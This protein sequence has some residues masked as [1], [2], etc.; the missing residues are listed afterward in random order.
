MQPARLPAGKSAAKAIKRAPI[1]R[2]K[3]RPVPSKPRAKTAPAKP[4]R[5][6]AKT[7]VV[8]TRQA[9]SKAFIGDDFL[10]S[11]PQAVE[12]FHAYAQ[13]QPIVDYHCHLPPDRIASDQP[14]ANLT[15]IWLGGDHYKWRAMRANGIDERLI[16]GD[17]PDREK[18]AAWAE[19]V[20]KCLRNPLYHWT[21]L[22]L[23]RPFGITDKLLGPDTAQD[24]WDRANSK[25]ARAD[26]SPRGIMRQMNVKVVCTTD[27]PVDDLAHHQATAI[28]GFDVQVRPTWRPDKGLLVD[29]PALFNPWLDRLSA[30][31]GIAIHTWEDFQAAL[32]NRHQ[33]FHVAGCRLSD[34]GLDTVYAEDYSLAEIATIFAAARKGQAADPLATARFKSAMLFEG[35]VMDH[36]AGW[37]Q[38][39]HIGAIRNTNSRAALRGPDLGYDSIGEADYAAPLARLLDRL[40]KNDRLAR[41]ILYNLNPRTNEVLATMIGNFQDGRTPGKMQFGSGWWFLDQKDG[42]EKQIDCLSNMGLL[43]RFVGMLTD[44]RSFL[45]YT[46]HEYFRRILC[47]KL[48][49]EMADGLLPNDIGMI[50]NLVAD[51]CYRNAAAYFDFGL[52][53]Q[54]V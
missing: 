32:A 37:V 1:A 11:T 38:Q 33:F 40:D 36:A 2:A 44:S 52:P 6:P 7:T 41:T 20:P 8:R 49:R 42:M 31:S 30:A 14:F 28:S 45:S 5:P 51:V 22:E 23:R 18:F 39:F 13:Q 26:F 27:D 53:A 29:Q 48:G 17:A 19:T 47:N 3:P 12:L 21:H 9:P 54:G 16:T 15:D 46:R 50:G 34:H 10:L 24:I 35:A 4:A 25:L 43:S